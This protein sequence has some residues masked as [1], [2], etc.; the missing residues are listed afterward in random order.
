[1]LGMGRQDVETGYDDDKNQGEIKMREVERVEKL[2]Q[3]KLRLAEA[4]AS[5]QASMDKLNDE[6]VIV[7]T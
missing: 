7:K 3:T 2:K 1:L 5:F 4:K 6:L